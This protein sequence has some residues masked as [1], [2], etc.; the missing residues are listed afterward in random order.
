MLTLAATVV[1]GEN[2]TFP[3]AKATISLFPSDLLYCLRAQRGFGSRARSKEGERKGIGG[4]RWY[5][6]D[7]NMREKGIRI[8]LSCRFSTI[9]NG[10]HG[11]AAFGILSGRFFRIEDWDWIETLNPD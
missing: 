3:R 7:C 6:T 9:L 11:T 8:A 2:F 1:G 10:C 5:I 4:E